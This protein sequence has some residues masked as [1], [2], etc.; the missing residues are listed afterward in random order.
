MITGGLRGIG[1]EVCKWMLGKGDTDIGLP[2]RNPPSSEV[3]QSIL[4]LNRKGFNVLVKLG[5]VSDLP[6]CSTILKEIAKE[7]K[8]L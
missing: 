4:D 2:A 3:H 7:G 8:N 6:R 5:E 1:F